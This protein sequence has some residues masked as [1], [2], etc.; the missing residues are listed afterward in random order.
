MQGKLLWP[1]PAI[2]DPSPT[3]PAKGSPTA[4]A[5]EVKEPNYFG[6]TLKDA[7]MYSAGLGGILGGF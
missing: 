4:V 1:P 5:A 7:F 2:K 3:V 6:N